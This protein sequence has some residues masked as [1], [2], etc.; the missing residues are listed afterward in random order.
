MTAATGRFVY[1]FC[2]VSSLHLSNCVPEVFGVFG[3]LK[4]VQPK[5][6]F[7]FAQHPSHFVSCSFVLSTSNGLTESPHHSFGEAT[8]IGSVMEKTVDTSRLFSFFVSI[9]IF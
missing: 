3:F 4:L 5:C 7:R 8:G 1:V 6:G 9:D 2:D